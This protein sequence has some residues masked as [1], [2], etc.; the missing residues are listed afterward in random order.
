MSKRNHTHI[1]VVLPEI[2]AMLAEGKAQREVASY[3][4]FKINQL[5]LSRIYSYGWN[6]I[7]IR[8]SFFARIISITFW[9]S[10]RRLIWVMSGF[11]F[12]F[13]STM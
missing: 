3:Y 10:S 12:S 7:L 8:I 9:K 4:R 5:K 13:P 1:Q 2:K 11:T 6:K